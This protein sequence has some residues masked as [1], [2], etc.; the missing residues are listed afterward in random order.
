MRT[1]PQRILYVDDDADS[2]EMI[3]F[4]LRHQDSELDVTFAESSAVGVELA[5][6]KDFDLYIVDYRMPE[7]DGAELCTRIRS[8]QPDARVLFYSA[9]AR[10]IEI[11][12]AFDAGAA[13]F[14]VKPNDLDLLVPTVQKLLAE[15]TADRERTKVNFR[16]AA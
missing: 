1:H 14:L 10:E 7:M 9:V 15:N 3:G 8:M 12:N 6:G 2:R 4:W 5:A 11:T 16:D 13:E